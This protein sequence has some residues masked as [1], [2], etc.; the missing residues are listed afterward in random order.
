LLSRVTT[1]LPFVPFTEEERMAIAGEAV[2][3]VGGELA[4]SLPAETVNAMARQAA[5]AG[6]IPREGA[7]SLYR[8]VAVRLMDAL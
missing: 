4:K 2:L 8:D 6:Y 3:G 7:R 5:S 1:A